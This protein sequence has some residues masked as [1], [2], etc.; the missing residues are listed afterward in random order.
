MNGCPII[1]NIKVKPKG[2]VK[3]IPPFGLDPPPLEVEKNKV[4]F[5]QKLDHFLSTF[6]KK[7][8]FTIENPKKLLLDKQIFA[9]SDAR[10][11]CDTRNDG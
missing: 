2:R 5:F 9:S 6:C 4:I 7:C 11:C 1:A 8:I 10:F 3:K